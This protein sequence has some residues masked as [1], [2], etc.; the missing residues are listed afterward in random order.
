[1][2]AAGLREAGA[3][4]APMLQ[5]RGTK[6]VWKHSPNPSNPILG[7]ESSPVLLSCPS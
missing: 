3:P 7:L 1:M 4:L 6:Q 2:A 5:C